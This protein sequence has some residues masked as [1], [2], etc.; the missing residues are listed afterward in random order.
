MKLSKAKDLPVKRRRS[1][2]RTI[3]IVLTFLPAWHLMCRDLF[4]LS[5]SNAM[6]STVFNKASVLPY[7]SVPIGFVATAYCENG[8][9]KS[10]VPVAE[11]IVAA[12]E[13]VLP[14]GSWIQVDSP[15]YSGVYHVMDTGRLV[16]GKK[17]D[18]Y[19][20]SLTK[21]IKF[22]VKQVRVTVLKYGPIHRKPVPMVSG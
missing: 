5:A 20:P 12:D 19:I 21:A 1:V 17:I 14:L 6:G 8:I 2:L 16:R 7:P 3:L 11:G 13:H 15:S 9:T 22:G 18:I 10:G 4:N